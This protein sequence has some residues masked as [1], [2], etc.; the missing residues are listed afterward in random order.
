MET[1]GN[2]KV[3][4]LFLMIITMLLYI[5][6]IWMGIWGYK[7]FYPY[8]INMV[9]LL[10]VMIFDTILFYACVRYMLKARVWISIFMT[11]SIVLTLI[12]VLYI[13]EYYSQWKIGWY[14]YP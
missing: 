1:K 8:D 10:P 13:L 3:V 14:I 2:N 12:I 11:M 7:L 5:K 9:W 6:I 4:H